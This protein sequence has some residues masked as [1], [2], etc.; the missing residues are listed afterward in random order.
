M[1]ISSLCRSALAL[2]LTL[3]CGSFHHAHAATIQVTIENLGLD[4]ST[5]VTP[6]F[7]GFGDGTFT[8]FTPGQS[9]TTAIERLAEDGNTGPL[10][11]AFPFPSANRTTLVEGNG[12][13]TFD[14]GESATATFDIDLNGGTNRLLL[15]TMLLPTNDWFIA[16][17]GNG[18]DLSGLTVSSPISFELNRLY[19]AGT[20]VNDF[21]TS[22][23]NGLFGLSGGQTGPNIGT[24][25]NGVVTFL[26]EIGINDRL[27]DFE[28]SDPFDGRPVDFNPTLSPLRVT[29]SAVP[30][31][32]TCV[33]A[34]AFAIG[35][36]VAQRRR[37]RKD[38]SAVPQPNTAS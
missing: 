13:P 8:P 26:G 29:V 36:L 17:Q 24:D 9:A 34:G 6:V 12:P 20:E 10:E 18:V 1:R 37:R 33:A 14:A 7:I 30:E 28:G 4:G 21:A 16:T 15:A 19:D 25:E 3:A 22:A 32:A 23:A 38:R 11:S 35:G 2:T 27:A 31:P 5:H